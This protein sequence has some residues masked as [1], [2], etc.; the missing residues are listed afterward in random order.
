MYP[1]EQQIYGPIVLAKIGEIEAVRK[2]H[3]SLQPLMLPTWVSLPLKEDKPFL[4]PDELMK[5]EI[6]AVRTGSG[7]NVC[8]WDPRHL[9]MA[10]EPARDAILLNFLLGKF[11]EFGCKVI[12][13][14]SLRE[15]Y[16][17][18]SVMADH[19]KREGSGI[20]VRLRL[21]DLEEYEL[22]ESLLASAGITSESCMLLI[23]LGQRDFAEHDEF[24]A[25]LIRWVDAL[26]ERG[27]WAKIVVAGTSYPRTNPA[28]EGGEASP[29]RSEWL[30]WK[31]ALQL[32]PA[33]GERA[34]YGDFGPE[35][36]VKDFGGGRGAIPHIR[37]AHY[38]VCRV[39]RGTDFPSMRSVMRRVATAPSFMGRSYSAG[40][41]FIADCAS[42]VAENCGTPSDWRFANMNHHFTL[43]LT[44][45]AGLY[46]VGTVERVALNNEQLQL[47]DV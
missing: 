34:T 24:A 18:L 8:C 2:L 29:K 4:R 22:L 9:K 37:Y 7:E 41:E 14:A 25:S 28:L 12:P 26:R 39:V 27:N 35:R 47:T 42:G 11:V 38:E 21:D 36:E 46:G 3:S 45:L 13:V 31:W 33:F 16:S 30:V 32:D 23:D 19:S 5:R 40:D 20:A 15:S 17:R 10:E 1:V 43:I 44:T 6:G